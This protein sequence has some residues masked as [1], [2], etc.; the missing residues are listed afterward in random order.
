MGSHVNHYLAVWFLCSPPSLAHNA[1]E[2]RLYTQT[3][4][5]DHK[6]EAVALSDVLLSAHS[7][8]R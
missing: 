6:N 4:T 1:T 5:G 2:L 3:C 8:E 7:A